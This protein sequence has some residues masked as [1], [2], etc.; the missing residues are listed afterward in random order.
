M[1]KKNRRPRGSVYRRSDSPYWYIAYSAGRQRCRENTRTTNLKTAKKLLDTRLG[2]IAGGDVLPVNVGKTT[3]GELLELVRTDYIINNLKSLDDA[4]RR[5]KLH[6]APFFYCTV[7][8]AGKFRDGMKANEVSSDF[9]NRYVVTRQQ[10]GASNGTVNRELSLLRR[11]FSLGITA[12]PPKV[13]RCPRFPRLKEA[14][15]R[16]GFL[17]ADQYH[18]I[19]QACPELWFRAMVEV[20]NTYGWR[21]TEIKGL[22]SDQVDLANRSIR[23]N[24]GS[25]KNDEARL[26]F[27]TDAVYTLLSEC[28]RGK[29]GDDYVF[30]RANGKAVLDFRAT[31]HN[32]CVAA[33][34]G[35]WMCPKCEGQKLDVKGECSH[36]GQ[37]WKR[38]DWRYRGAIFHDWRRTGV[39]GMVRRGIPE[40]V[41]MK[42]SGHKTR[43]VYDRYNILNETDLRDAA[44]KM[45]KPIP[46][47]AELVPV[48]APVAPARGTG[49]IN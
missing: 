17:E 9:V 5:M 3:I 23:L 11:G 45:N 41:G 25:T 18:A 8:Q 48:S 38:R 33:G 40:L 16:K 37:T 49:T 36:C 2:A 4:E 6:L 24:P 13:L 10:A 47:G 42:I 32:A 14:A 31:W 15:P 19:T 26:V 29:K 35:K 1:E 21:S 34:V 43:S 7:D 22:R 27:M 12:T 20:A 28:V 30:T 44:R 46:D 39:R